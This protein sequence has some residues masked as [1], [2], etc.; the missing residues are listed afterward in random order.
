MGTDGVGS[1]I[2]GGCLFTDAVSEDS[3]QKTEGKARFALKK[4]ATAD[5]LSAD[6]SVSLA[7]LRDAGLWGDSDAAVRD[8]LQRKD[9]GTT[10]K[11]ITAKGLTAHGVA[12]FKLT[13]V[14]SHLAV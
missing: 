4:R 3:W 12:L 5:D 6:V 10:T 14:E 1:D 11:A 2:G 8:V 9:L 7:T 13:P